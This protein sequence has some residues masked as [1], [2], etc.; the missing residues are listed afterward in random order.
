MQYRQNPDEE[1]SID[2]LVREYMGILPPDPAPAPPPPLD[3]ATYAPL[4]R[5]GDQVVTPPAAPAPGTPR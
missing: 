1:P 2:E 4:A 3:P 5:P